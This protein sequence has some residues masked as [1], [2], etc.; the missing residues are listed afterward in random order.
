MLTISK[1]LSAGQA[2]AY[3]QEEFSNAQEN[4]DSEGDRIRG[5]WHGKLAEKWGLHGG[6][7]EEQFQRLSDGQHPVS[8]EQLVRHQAMRE[9]LNEQGKTIKTMEHRAG[10]DA[11]FSAPKSVSLTALVGG[12]ERVQEAHRASVGVALD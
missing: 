6:V 9:Y 5:E 1:P 3:H 4:Y 8:G 2:R 10:W 12:D 11:T 7:Q